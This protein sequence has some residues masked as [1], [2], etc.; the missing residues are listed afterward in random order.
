MFLPSEI[1]VEI[2]GYLEKFDLK[3]VRL[4]SHA[5]SQYA[6]RFLF[7]TVYIS[8]FKTDYEVFINMAEHQELSKCVKYL[9]Y[10]AS[11]FPDIT[12]RYYLW[13]TAEQLMRMN[14]M[15]YE[16]APVDSPDPEINDLVR[17][18]TN[19][20]AGWSA[21]ANKHEA[22]PRFAS[23]RFIEE[24]YLRWV[25]HVERQRTVQRNYWVEI[26]W[27]L[28]SFTN[29]ESFEM[30]TKWNKHG[31]CR[32]D[33]LKLSTYC[34]HHLSGSPLYRSWNVAHLQPTGWS[35]QTAW[36]SQPITSDG[37]SEVNNMIYLLWSIPN[38]AKSLR[39]EKT[40]LPTH[41]L[42]S[43]NPSCNY[44]MESNFWPY[45]FLQ[46]LHLK[47]GYCDSLDEDEHYNPIDGLPR[48]LCEIPRLKSL[49]LDLPS[50][51]GLVH[52][53]YTLQEVFATKPVFESL[54][55]LSLSHVSTDVISWI[56]LLMFRMKNLQHLDLR[57]I[58]LR[59]G[60][61]EEV[62]ECMHLYMSLRSVS[63]PYRRDSML[64]PH[65]KVFWTKNQ[66]L[67]DAAGLWKYTNEHKDFI[68]DIEDYVVHGGRHPC[69]DFG[70]PEAVIV[71]A[72]KKLLSENDPL[73]SSTLFKWTLLRQSR[74][75]PPTQA[76]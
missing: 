19:R 13:Y 16:N 1:L 7:D 74:S 18:V 73:R 63:F 72:S 4:T 47:F 3:A 64:Y 31:W 29:I 26:A 17:V 20:Q 66:R 58:E 49:N 23:S 65:R 57:A 30:Y 48:L 24:G 56:T 52:H 43:S 76:I 50:D 67:I 61:W 41:A 36:L 21:R 46:H 69:L 2:F 39:V 37:I 55:S 35:F 59:Q 27:K 51:N 45:N 54:R 60:V 15:S 10:D 14:N 53:I 12:K 32:I 68:A 44:L 25:E 6:N 42:T 28:A 8:A 62:I 11:Q 70:Q 71:E 38:R 5:C 75:W 9:K 22:W 34:E 33:T 40:E